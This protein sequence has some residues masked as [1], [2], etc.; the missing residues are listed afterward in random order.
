MKPI[1]LWETDRCPCGEGLRYYIFFP[2]G[3][4]HEGL[5]QRYALKERWDAAA[6]HWSRALQD[7]SH[8]IMLHRKLAQAYERMG[9]SERANYYRQVTTTHS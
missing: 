1:H 3:I 8:I 7:G 9:D 2:E 4:D 5:G 6:Y